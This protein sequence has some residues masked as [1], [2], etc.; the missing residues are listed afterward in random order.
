MFFEEFYT[1]K[2]FGYFFFRGKILK[3]EIVQIVFFI[4]H[5][6]LLRT[7]IRLTFRR[8]IV[9]GCITSNVNPD[10]SH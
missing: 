5:L 6:E 1:L 10:C 3:I 7:S 2:Y 8:K 9:K 4:L